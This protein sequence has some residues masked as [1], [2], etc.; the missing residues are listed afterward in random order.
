MK[1]LATL[2]VTWGQRQVGITSAQRKKRFR[3]GVECM[4]KKDL[5]SRKETHVTYLPHGPLLHF[6]S[7]M[8]MEVWEVLCAQPETMIKK[9]QEMKV[10]DYLIPPSLG[11]PE[12][13]PTKAGNRLQLRLI[14]I[15]ILLHPFLWG[16]SLSPPFHF[17]QVSFPQYCSFGY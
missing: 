13:R 15:L 6:L 10:K 3:D 12:R 1:L 2:L 8:E 5:E 7:L 16:P 4:Q 14:S 11:V 17:L 9:N